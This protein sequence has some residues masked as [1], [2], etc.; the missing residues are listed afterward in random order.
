MPEINWN[1]AIINFENESGKNL[2]YDLT[3]FITEDN[4]ERD[5]LVKETL[6]TFAQLIFLSL[7]SGT[8]WTIDTID[9]R[10]KLKSHNV[11]CKVGYDDC[12]VSKITFILSELQ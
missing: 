4:D 6:M 12:I 2:N 1:N 10:Y 3:K 5:V 9:G 8:P 11:S 7:P